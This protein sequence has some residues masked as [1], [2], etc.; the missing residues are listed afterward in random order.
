MTHKEKQKARSKAFFQ[1]KFK[2][3]DQQRPKHLTQVSE[4][5]WEVKKIHQI[6][7]FLDPQG[8]IIESFGEVEWKNTLEPLVNMNCNH[9][10]S[11]CLDQKPVTFHFNDGATEQ[12][13]LKYDKDKIDQP[14]Y[15]SNLMGSLNTYKGDI[16]KYTD[17]KIHERWGT[18]K[19]FKKFYRQD[20]EE[21]QRP[22]KYK[23]NSDFEKW[24]KWSKN[25][26]SDY[27]DF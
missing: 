7:S 20:P 19:E 9:E 15:F 5:V 4:T 16:S 11:K 13:R 24:E 3:N 27:D 1:K 10:I 18:N 6:H 2:G 25:P 26:F 21:E 8:K 14:D 17:Q 12:W 23:K 22:F